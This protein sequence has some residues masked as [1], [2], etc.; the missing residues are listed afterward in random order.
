M[1]LRFRNILSANQ[2]R[3]GAD[4][5][6]RDIREDRFG[7]A[8]YVDVLK[9]RILKTDTPCTIGIL[10]SWGSGKSSLMGFL[11]ADIEND[12]NLKGSVK[13]IWINVWELGT[14]EEVWHAFLQAIFS[15]VY[16]KIPW[17]RKIDWRK[18]L[19]QAARNSWRVLVAAVPAVVAVYLKKSGLPLTDAIKIITFQW[20]SRWQAVA[21]L[22]TQ[23]VALATVYRP[24]LDAVKKSLKFDVNAVL[25]AGSY[26]AQISELM[27]LRTRFEKVV[28]LA[29]GP[30]GRI[31]VF[32]DDL[33]RCTPDKVPEVLE[34]IKLFASTKGCVYVLGFDQKV[35]AGRIAKKYGFGEDEGINYLEKIVQIPFEFPPLDPTDIKKFISEQYKEF[36]DVSEVFAKGLTANPRTI[37]RALNTYRI[38]LRM[39]E[40]R[41]AAWEIDPLDPE[42]VAKVIVIQTR[43]KKLYGHLVDAPEDLV[44]F[45]DWAAMPTA[46]FPNELLVDTKD[47]NALAAM[48]KAGNSKFNGQD[49]QLRWYI[50]LGG[51]AVG[52]SEELRPD[53]KYRE[54][55]LSN[56]RKQIRAVFQE[57]MGNY[58]PEFVERIRKAYRRRLGEILGDVAYPGE[59]RLSATLALDLLDNFVP[60]AE[61]EAAQPADDKYRGPETVRVAS[62]ESSMGGLD[63]DIVA[64][65]KEAGVPLTLTKQNQV[66]YS[67]CPPDYRIG[68]YP[69]TN[70]EFAR[71]EKSPDKLFIKTQDKVVSPTILEAEAYFRPCRPDGRLAGTFSET[72]ASYQFLFESDQDPEGC[73]FRREDKG[74]VVCEIKVH[75]VTRGAEED[76][77]SDQLRR[78]L[79]CE[80]L[81]ARPPIS[82]KFDF[83]LKPGESRKQFDGGCYLFVPRNGTKSVFVTEGLF[84]R[85]RIM[86]SENQELPELPPAGQYFEVDVA[87]WDRKA[88]LPFQPGAFQAH[89][90]P[91]GQEKYP[92]TNINWNRAA[93]YCMWLG[94]E[95]GIPYRLPTETEWELAATGGSY[96][97]R[98]FPWGDYWNA[99]LANTSEGGRRT[100]SEV[101]QYPQGE[102]PYCCSDMAGNVWEWCA[103]SYSETLEVERTGNAWQDIK[104]HGALSTAVKNNRSVRGGSYYDDNTMAVCFKRL[105]RDVDYTSPA[106]GFRVA[107]SSGWGNYFDQPV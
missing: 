107:V 52:T 18:L 80:L 72:P 20:S 85:I 23:L 7:Y 95:T 16:K 89:G 28:K 36:D 6:L 40:K 51:D 27:K 59:Q 55:L 37:K 32:I 69:V 10:G 12:K 54:R 73:V 43:F 1:T 41:V 75:I 87:V 76:D 47:R 94:R 34:A 63:K 58:T 21:G 53:S 83:D 19:D 11:D 50:F 44:T 8:E 35:V 9:D 64:T 78:V 106:Q 79:E 65:A 4:R 77:T 102:S 60:D 62:L 81:E 61:G 88:M 46:A 90:F 96:P 13:T 99:S 45:E 30:E 42:L 97:P 14:Q 71:F 74:E 49:K 98:L 3:M 56:D 24:A 2:D 25:K 33:D 39:V 26:E 103:D 22:A 48:L 82:H 29:A 38:L 101:G 5:E 57:A 92:A 84:V 70:E 93:L 105:G 66:W 17:H 86:S 91:A 68:R 104:L 31:A 67:V 15:K 100:T